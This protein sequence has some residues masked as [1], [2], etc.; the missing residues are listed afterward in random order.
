MAVYEVLDFSPALK[1][2]VL[3]GATALEL[4]K[5]AQEEGMRSL[6]QCALAKVAEGRTSLEEALAMTMEN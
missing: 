5:K 1:E 3:A 6:R 2:M 4:R